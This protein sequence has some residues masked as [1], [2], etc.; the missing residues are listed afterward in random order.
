MIET[1]YVANHTHTDIGFTDHQDVCFRQHAEFI[2]QAMDVIEATADHPEEARFR[3]T[4]EVTGPLE[5]YLATASEGEVDRFLR[6]NASGAMDVAAMQYNLTPLLGVEQMVRSLMPVRRLRE[7][8]VRIRSAMQDDVNGISWLFADL[9]P[10]IGVDTLTLAINQ[11]RGRAPKPLPG[12]FWWE[13]PAGGRLLCWNGL[14]YL[15][16]RS[17]AK[18]AD[19]RYVER[20]LAALVR[21]VQSDPDYPYDFL[22]VEATHPMRVDNGP[23]ERRVSDFV[24]EWNAAGRTPR[25][26]LTTPAAFGDVLRRHELPTWRGDWTD[27]WSDGAASSAYETGLNRSTHELLGAAEAIAAWTGTGDPE[28]LDALYEQMSL[29]DEHTWGAFASVARPDSL[30][31]KAQWNRKSGY[32]YGAAME[33]HDVLAR[34]AGALARREGEP[35]AESRFNLGDLS[36]EEAFPHSGA[37]EWLVINTLPHARRV[38]VEEP[39][40]RAGGAPRGMLDMFFPRDVP[41]GGARSLED[42]RVARAELPPCG[43]AWVRFDGE[44]AAADL[45]VAP[46]VIE[47]AHYRVEVDPATGGLRSWLDKELGHDFAGEQ[48]GHRLGQYVYER[49]EGDRRALF[50]D[51]FSEWDFGVWPQDVPLR[52]SAPARVTVGEPE[53]SRGRASIAVAIEAEGVRG[54]TCRYTLQSDRRA[55]EIDWTLDKLAQ[56]EPESVYIAFPFALGAPGFR[57]DL[58]GVACTP[59]I[60]Q[61][62]GTVRDWYP[63]RRWVDV[64]DGERGVTLAPLDAPLAQLGGITTGR[65]AYEL[66]PDGPAVYSWAL[67]NHWSVNFRAF[68]EGEIPLRYR[69]TTH[70]GACDDAAAARF[71]AEAATP[72]LVLRDWLRRGDERGGFLELDGD[73]VELALKPAEDG[74][75]IVARLHDQRGEARVVRLSFATP[76]ASVHLTSPL[77]H[78]GESLELRDGA[79]AVL[80]G[81]RALVSLRVR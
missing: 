71:A 27:W 32:A 48:D 29:Y 56:P 74:D 47:N 28:R 18:L 25:I 40:V 6:H 46:G 34:A 70:A 54:A 3:W 30:F 1:L 5:K 21:R 35:G 63:L 49:V 44:P 78:D 19:P 41:W 11:M 12:A 58:N 55:L 45:A 51:D 53:I 37:D 76:P 10:A 69:L 60:D 26:E 52:R 22:Y 81:A 20:D 2:S 4:C 42:V 67:N 59:D 72:P 31:T 24:A 77:E 57:A 23:P 16:G 50:A 64:S 36:Y 15:F 17:V 38:L 73:G 43:W 39:E 9:L 75:G 14:H 66:Q 7:R 79:V 33:T 13:G 80:L 65:A 62:N 68:Q 61:L 8:G